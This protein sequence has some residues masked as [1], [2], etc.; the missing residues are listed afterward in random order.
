MHRPTFLILSAFSSAVALAAFVSTA[1]CSSSSN[2]TSPAQV[3]T[4]DAGAAC[5]DGFQPIEDGG[6]CTAILSATDCAAGTTPVIGNTSCVPVGVTSCAPGFTKSASGWGC[7]A[8]LPTAICTGA[9]RESIGSA[10]CVPVGD[11]TAAFPPSNATIF[12]DASYTAGQID[13]T[14]FAAVDAALASAPAGAVIAVESGAYT[15]VMIPKASVSIVGRCAEK[16]V[17]T[18]TDATTTAIQVGPTAGT[19]SFSGMT[20][21]NYHGAISILAGKATV[22][23]VVVDG[24]HFAGI[25]AGN[26]GTKLDIT[27]SVVRGTRIGATDPNSFGLYLGDDAWVTVENSSFADND[28]INVGASGQGT[29]GA[30]LTLT[31]S[32][33]RNAHPTGDGNGFGWGVLGS[34]KVTLDIEQSVLA[35]NQGFGLNMYATAAGSAGAV[36]V[37]DS[38]VE[39]TTFDPVN[40]Q[41]IGIEASYSSLDIENSTVTDNDA[42]D[43]YGFSNT[44]KIVSTT[45]GGTSNTDPTVLGPVGLLLYSAKATLQSIAVIGTR[46]GAELQET[47]T[48]ELDDSVFSGTRTS[49]SGYYLQGNYVG[50]GVLLE[51]KAT[52]TSKNTAIL[53]THTAGLL[54]AGNATVT[55]LLVQGTRAGGDKVAGRAVSVQGGASFTGSGCAFIDNSESGIAVQ[56]STLTL[57]DSIIDKTILDPLGQYGIG[58]LLFSTSSAATISTTTLRGGAGPAL[59]V[60]SG[61]ASVSRSAFLDNSVAVYVE[62]GSSLVEGDGT[63]DPMTVAIS[64]DTVFDGNTTRVASGTIPLPPSL[65]TP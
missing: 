50:V 3:D 36:T 21:A 5:A 16:V 31:N 30:K 6:G 25:I 61:G 45:V 44:T 39:G 7:D 29:A 32:V 46:T 59:A 8:V 4:S 62:G 12:V 56:D 26:V 58:I 54:T 22:D 40:Q 55:G 41:G 47:T 2:A 9:T 48:A 57:T 52:L 43:V 64:S 15:G 13:A 28:Y 19:F 10:T 20:F 49:A 53:N 17:F 23:S 24:S 37:K 60:S 35:A 34:G 14:H 65:K 38:L 42:E 27:N 33:V 1:G 11:C 18:A 51:T 63:G